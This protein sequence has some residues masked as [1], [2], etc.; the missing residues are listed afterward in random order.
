[1]VSDG[2]NNL[3]SFPALGNLLLQLSD[4]LR[5][6]F[7]PF[8]PLFLLLLFELISPP[9]L[10]S[11][12][13]SCDDGFR[14]EVSEEPLASKLNKPAEGQVSDHGECETEFELVWASHEIGVLRS[15]DGTYW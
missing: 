10:S 14:C 7:L 6:P 3:P 11:F 9:G 15:T 13:S 2:T 1:M 8:S 12:M 4:L 5:L